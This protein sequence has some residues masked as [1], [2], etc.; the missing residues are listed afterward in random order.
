VKALK[1]EGM[2]KN[3]YASG[4]VPLHPKLIE[5]GLLHY[6]ENVRASGYENLFPDAKKACDKKYSTWFQKPWA[7]YLRRL[8]VKKGRKEC[9]HTFRHNWNE[10]LRRADVREE[11]QDRLGGWKT[12]GSAGRN[13]GRQPMD[14]LLKYL[15]KLEYPGLDL[16][17]FCHKI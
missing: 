5:F 14:R 4:W 17:A 12:P 8:G 10:G 3:Q 2:V 6:V 7:N 1:L 16:N 13:Y 11:I 9:F 15:E